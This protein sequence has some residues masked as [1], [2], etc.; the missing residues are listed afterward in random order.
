MGGL[1]GFAGDVDS[2]AGG[3]ESSTGHT[4]SLVSDAESP[5]GG[6]ESSAGG[7]ESSVGNAKVFGGFIGFL[8][9]MPGGVALTAGPD[10]VPANDG[11]VR[12]VAEGT[13]GGLFAGTGADGVVATELGAGVV[14]GG[15]AGVDAAVTEEEGGIGVVAMGGRELGL[16]VLLPPLE[17]T[18]ATPTLPISMPIAAKAAKIGQRRPLWCGV[19][20]APAEPEMVEGSASW[21]APSSRAAGGGSV[22]TML[23]VRCTEIAAW[24]SECAYFASACANSATF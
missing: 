11:E 9:V 21:V 5:A 17:A 7:P 15:G 6:S 2:F 10:E 16:S 4:E 20:I 1:S 23:L 18:N 12:V 8:A 22:L 14:A 19:V 24:A 13:S 3:A